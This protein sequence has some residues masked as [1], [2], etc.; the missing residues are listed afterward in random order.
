MEY[1]A[2]DKVNQFQLYLERINLRS[3]VLSNK[4]KSQEITTVDTIFIELKN[5]Q[6]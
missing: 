2:A 3:I 5:K 4:S 1:Q 6:N